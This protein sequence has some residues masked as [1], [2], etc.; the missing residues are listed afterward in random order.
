MHH[1]GEV[2]GKLGLRRFIHVR[3]TITIRKQCQNGH[4]Q[5]VARLVDGIIG[6][7]SKISACLSQH[8]CQC[9]RPVG[10]AST[11][12]GDHL[13][14]GVLDIRRLQRSR[15]IR[16]YRSLL[17]LEFFSV[18]TILP[19]GF[20]S[21]EL[22]CSYP[23]H[24]AEDARSFHL[25]RGEH[26]RAQNLSQPGRAPGVDSCFVSRG[27]VDEYRLWT[28]PGPPSRSRQRRALR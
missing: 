1:A 13:G 12:R 14:L 8:G 28:K 25:L 11:G 16:L 3:G 22:Q 15:F 5:W 9:R 19:V 23:P 20:Y 2:A 6:K 18:A 7:I 17:C 10:L 27:S 21:L 4:A 24:N 26:R